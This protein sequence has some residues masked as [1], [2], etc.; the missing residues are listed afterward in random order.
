M[1]EVKADAFAGE[2]RQMGL[3]SGFAAVGLLLAAAGIYGLIAYS[4]AQRTKEIGLRIALGATRARILRSILWNGT[5]LA[6]IGIVAG[7]AASIATSKAIAGLV[8]GVSPLD[9]VTFAG[10]ALVLLL[11]SILASVVPALRA[12]RLNPISALRD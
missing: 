8:W 9:P 10:V 12:V 3:L 5:A 2:R 1:D 4:V 6:V 7:I 11:V